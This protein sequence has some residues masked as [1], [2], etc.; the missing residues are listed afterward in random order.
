MKKKI[1]DIVSNVDTVKYRR[2]NLELKE[3]ELNKLK[4]SKGN[5]EEEIES[6]EKDIKKQ[7]A[8]N[9][10]GHLQYAFIAIGIILVIV[11]TFIGIFFA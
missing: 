1:K 10:F 3:S 9:A 7:K 11:S 2:E 5:K 4:N 6:L 8:K